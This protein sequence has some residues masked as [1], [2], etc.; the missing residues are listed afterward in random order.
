MK[1]AKKVLVVVD[2]QNDFC[3][4]GKLGVKDGDKV[5]GP[6]NKYIAFFRRKKLP[7]FA[8]RDWH[9]K[10]TKHFKIYGGLWPVHCVQR[11]RGASF[12]KDL[13]I[14]SSALI[15][16]KGMDPKQEGYSVFSAKDTQRRGLYKILRT[17]G[18]ED[19]Y[20]GGLTTE[21]CVKYTVLDALK[22]GF[23]A[24]FLADAMKEVNPADGKQAIRDM[25]Q[26]GARRITLKDINREL[27]RV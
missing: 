9:P 23:K 26:A 14:P 5:V 3:P 22:Y 1:K 13:K 4:G 18:V 27:S 2:V 15:L 20:I 7:I 11:T 10:K 19:L 25:I 17:M 21:Y 8:T 12:R 16:S 24:A 6:L